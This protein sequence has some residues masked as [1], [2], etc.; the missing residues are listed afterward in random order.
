MTQAPEPAERDTAG[1]RSL[2]RVLG[3]FHEL[4][5]APQ[6]MALGELSSVL[7][8]P[9]S[10]LLNLLRPLVAEG[11]LVN[12]QGR[13][14]LG[15]AAFRLCAGVQSAWNFSKLIRPFMEELSARTGETVLLGVINRDAGVLTYVEVID[16][17]H[18]VRYQISAG[19]T[20]PLYASSAGRLLLAYSDE[21]WLNEYLATLVIK[22][23]TA[24]PITKKWLRDSL[25]QIRREGVAWAIDHY[26]AGLGSVVAPVLDADGRCLASLSIAGPSSRFRADLGK[27]TATVQEVASRASGMI[28]GVHLDAPEG[29]V[30][31]PSVE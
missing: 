22:V 21:A 11:Y 1:P 3:M 10:S 17:A 4:S 26:L 23:R 30:P 24:T 19:T 6:G 16:S 14:R 5:R 18:P 15:G 31:A 27:L 13:Y 7:E 12:E 20:R 28:G 9:K 25:A 29:L 8:T 2:R